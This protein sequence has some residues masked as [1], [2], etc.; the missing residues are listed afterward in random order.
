MAPE[1]PEEQERPDTPNGSARPPAAASAAGTAPEA[2]APA[3]LPPTRI[4]PGKRPYDPFEP[5]QP[6][7][8]YGSAED[9]GEI[10]AAERSAARAADL[11][12]TEGFHPLRIRPYVGEP[13]E[14]EAAPTT[15]RSLLTPAGAAADGPDGPATADLGLFAEQYAGREYPQDTADGSHGRYGAGAGYDGDGYDGDDRD[16]RE[17]D[18]DGY[19]SHG[20]A[21]GQD[22]DGWTAAER[23]AAAAHG[24]HRRRRRRIVVAA[25][26]VAASALAAG[27]VAVTGQVM[28]DE[29]DSTGYALPDTASD[30]PEVTLPADAEPATATTAAPVTERAVRAPRT[31]SPSPSAS[32]APATTPPASP[33]PTGSATASAGPTTAT[34]TATG[35]SAPPSSPSTSTPSGDGAPPAAGGVLRLGDSGPAVAG[36]QRRLT[37]VWVY[38]GPI[39]GVFDEQVRQAVA[40][41]QVWYW[42]S[43]APDGSH[44]GVYG[45]HTRAVL[46]RQTSGRH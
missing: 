43:D 14:P 12:A 33:T 5:Y 4:V 10:R 39:D 37:Q 20:Y 22:P 42:V 44:D 19:D 27:A 36:L 3:A 46:E 9:G 16:D 15:V 30:T 35:S 40:T 2:A 24:R 7:E 28:G 31:A 8:P 23:A 17:Y 29:Q 38:D 34:P 41:F 1:Q 18:G 13:D 6:Y 45:P 21:D 26:A 32:T 25:A 11:A